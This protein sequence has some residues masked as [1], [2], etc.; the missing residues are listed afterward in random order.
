MGSLASRVNFDK[1]CTLAATLGNSG[2]IHSSF[3]QKCSD[4]LQ[5]G[6]EIDANLR[7]KEM[8]A[9]IGYEAKISFSQLS[10]LLNPKCVTSSCVDSLK[11][12]ILYTDCSKKSN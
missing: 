7:A 2:Q 3:W 4:Q 11:R 8:S 1:D 5:M 6:V 12:L 10:S 9:S